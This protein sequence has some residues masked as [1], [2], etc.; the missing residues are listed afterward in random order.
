MIRS[1]K[2]AAED[3]ELIF[4]KTFKCFFESA[5]AKGMK[6]AA[7]RDKLY[8]E[9]PFVMGV[10]AKR[11]YKDTDSKELIIVQGI[12]DAYYEEDDGIVLLDYK[13]DRV[14]SAE[15]LVKRYK[16]QLNLYEEAIERFSGKRVKAKFIYAFCLNET[17]EI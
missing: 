10:E 9:Q 8:R 13:T 17:I 14:D 1:G 2:I 7:K 15:Q 4:H 11:I 5:L 12:I 3:R 6:A 16:E